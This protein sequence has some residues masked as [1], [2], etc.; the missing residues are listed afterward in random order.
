[1]RRK[2]KMFTFN[3]PIH[4]TLTLL[5]W[6]AIWTERIIK[7]VTYIL[8][9]GR[10]EKDDMILTCKNLVSGAEPTSGGKEALWMSQ[11]SVRGCGFRF[12][13]PGTALYWILGFHQFQVYL[14]FKSLDV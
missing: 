12:V 4:K 1:M 3:H 2:A 10:E 6:S 8:W 11:N 7:K 5:F 14:I 13:C 9:E